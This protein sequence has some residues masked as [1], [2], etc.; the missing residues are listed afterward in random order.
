MSQ[1][2]LRIL[3]AN[4]NR[5]REA[6]R[7]I[8]EHVRFVLNSQALSERLKQLRHD[9]QRTVLAV[10]D[11]V[12]GSGHAHEHRDTP[13]DVGTQITLPSEMERLDAEH[14]VRAAFKRLQEAL[15]VL[16]E[17]G[18]TVSGS[19]A[20][21]L[22]DMRYAVYSIEP[23]VLADAS[24]RQRLEEARLYVLI[25]EDLASTDALTACR[26]AVA[27]GADIIQMREKSLEDAAFHEQALGMREIC[28]EGGA[29][30]LVN[31]RPHIA[32]LVNADGVHT[33][34]GDLPVHLTRRVIGHDRLI[35]R[36]TSAPEIAQ[37]A[38]DQGAD[39]V[40]VGPV[41]ETDTKKHR[42][43]VGLEYVRHAA[44]HVSLPWF[45]IGSINRETLPDVLGAGARAVAVCT[46]II[47]ATDIAG[48]S[49]WFRAEVVSAQDG[50]E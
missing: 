2:V 31:D 39:Y 47:G 36:S 38:L 30:F 10:F 11:S 4:S 7:V 48:E 37:A 26:E 17:Y 29:L 32:D 44:E 3:D 46:A 8:E 18:K 21:A 22:A 20:K 9:L 16:E 15:R 40:G 24:R 23:I 14:V 43:A 1:P 19:A 12:P 34:Q 41:H 49:A 13:G 27:G 35:G 42:A 50:A 25:T 28:Q 45:A 5:A 6:L 33:G